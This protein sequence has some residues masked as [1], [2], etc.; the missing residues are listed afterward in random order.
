MVTED[1]A[2]D[3]AEAAGVAAAGTAVVAEAAGPV[4]TVAIAVMAEAVAAEHAAD[5]AFDS[6][7]MLLGVTQGVLGVMTIRNRRGHEFAAGREVISRHQ[8]GNRVNRP[9]RPG[10]GCGYQAQ[11]EGSQ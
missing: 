9:I 6:G 11:T 8:P 4:A 1:S 7:E 2:A 10:V 3:S 5:V